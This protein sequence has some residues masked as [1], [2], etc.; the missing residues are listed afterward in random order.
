[1]DLA[2]PLAFYGGAAPGAAVKSG[3]FP[4]GKEINDRCASDYKTYFLL[5][6]VSLDL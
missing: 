1:M 4:K 5:Y 6:I 2:L 3:L